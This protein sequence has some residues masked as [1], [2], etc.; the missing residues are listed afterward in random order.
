MSTM[1]IGIERQFALEFA[2]VPEQQFV[3]DGRCVEFPEGLRT[4]EFTHTM[5]R[6]PG[7]FVPQVARELLMLVQANERSLIADPFCGS[8][9]S[10]VEASL[11]GIP[12]VGVDYD[13][14]AVLICR[15]KTVALTAMQLADLRR[16]WTGK[17]GDADTAD[18]LQAV[19]NLH[20]WFKP[21]IARQLAFIKKKAMKIEDESTRAFSLVVFSSIV[22]RVSNADDQTQKTYVSGTLKKTPPMPSELFPVFLDR[23]L[24]G[25]GEYAF[26]K[27]AL[28][29][30]ERAD[31][32]TWHGSGRVDGIVTSPPY[33][34]SIDYVYNQMLEYF[35]LYE[36]IGLTSVDDVRELRKEPVGFRRSDVEAGLER[37]GK[38]SP[39]ASELVEPFV[40][41]IRAVS[42]KEAEN[43]I[44]YF[45]DYSKHLQAI[46][47]SMRPGGVY[48]LVIGE[49]HI[50]GVTVPTPTIL[51]ALFE[52]HEFESIGS[53]SYMIKRHYMKFPRRSNSRKI[54][55]DY[56]CCFRNL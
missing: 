23:A 16:Y 34:D 36:F 14:L 48:A 1:S 25:M 35:W 28:V 40:T 47:R 26:C 44:G 9:T 3:L 19:P 21:A 11:A 13:P 5:H 46:K 52:S 30:V 42:T 12:T 51:S 32:R 2:A 39:L 17:I 15:A 54:N 8:G 7:K 38:K 22:R 20:H 53:C 4:A 49:S 27:R 18:L 31:A 45:E 37:L 29:V 24:K 6:F 50:R 43:V 55:V 56:V 33:I 10:L 41:K